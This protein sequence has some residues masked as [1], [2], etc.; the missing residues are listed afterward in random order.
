[1]TISPYLKGEALVR[2][3]GCNYWTH[4]D[5]KLDLVKET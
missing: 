4:L 1:M 3:C 2:G 5:S